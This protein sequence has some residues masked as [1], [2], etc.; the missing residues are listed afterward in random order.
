[1]N[2]LLALTPQ[3][4]KACQG[5]QAA[6]GA[7]NGSDLLA[8]FGTVAN[9]LIFIIGAIAVLMV[10]VGALRYVL[11]GGDAAGIKNARDTILYSLIGVAVAMISYALVQFVIG[12]L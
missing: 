2:I 3:G 12:R 4:T 8:S 10:I 5:V 7:C 6:G 9:V 11:S 1:M